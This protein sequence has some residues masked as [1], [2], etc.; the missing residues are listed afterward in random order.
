M[1]EEKIISNAQSMAIK[2]SGCADEAAERFR[3]KRGEEVKLPG[4]IRLMYSAAKVITEMYE[5]IQDQGQQLEKA[6]AV[7]TE[8]ASCNT[9]KNGDAKKCSIKSECGKEHSL[10]E[11]DV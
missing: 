5:H 6:M 10:W 3:A 9:C 2:L 7:I 1:T 11:F 4:Y 8:E